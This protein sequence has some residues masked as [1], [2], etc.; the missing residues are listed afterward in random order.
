MPRFAG[1]DINVP[2]PSSPSFVD[3]HG[4]WTDEQARLAA[5]VVQQIKKRKLELVRFSFADQHGVLRG[6]TLLAGE[7]ASAMKS[8]V[9]M[10]TTLLAKDT[11]HKTVF[12]VFTAGRRLQHGGNAG[13][14]RFRHGRR[15]RDLPRSAVGAEHRL[16]AVRHLFHQRQAGAVL[17]AAALSRRAVAARHRRLRFPRRARSRIP[18]VQDHQ[19]ASRAG[20]RHLAAGARRTSACSRRAISYLTETR[21]DQ[22]DAGA[23]S[24]PQGRARRSAC[25]C[26]RSK[27]SLGPSQCRVHLPHAERARRRRRH[28]PVPLGGEA[29]RAAQRLSRE[30]HVPARAA[31]H[32]VERL[33][34]A[35]VADREQAQASTPLR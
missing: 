10:T 7:A 19:P 33:A 11:A 12:P 13:R 2:P 27:S 17:D 23:R 26:A 20:G 31:E 35:S 3:R 15:S 16:A 25:R 28:D 14:R 5:A 30:L 18:S 4:L 8:G 24:D 32:D 1:H 6:K 9:N 34:P 29:D 22:I 21:F